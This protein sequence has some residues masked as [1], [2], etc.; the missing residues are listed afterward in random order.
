MADK[1]PAIGEMFKFLRDK[2][3]RDI[4]LKAQ[5]TF[6][7]DDIKWDELAYDV[8]DLILIKDTDNLENIVWEKVPQSNFETLRWVIQNSPENVD[9]SKI[10]VNAK[11]VVGLLAKDRKDAIDWDKYTIDSYTKAMA[12]LRH[13]GDDVNWNN[14]DYSDYPTLYMLNNKKPEVIDKSKVDMSNEKIAA[15]FSEQ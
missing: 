14:I 11:G 4:P 2:E 1:N 3:G 6:T 12:A 15:L 10:D 13:G 5:F 9:V 8:N 7:P